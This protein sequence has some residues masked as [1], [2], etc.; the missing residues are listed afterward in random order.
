MSDAGKWQQVDEDVR[1]NL[2]HGIKLVRTFRGHTGFI[3]NI[4]WSPDGRMLATPSFDKTIRLWDPETGKCLFTLEGHKNSVKCV[5]FDP[6]GHILAS[7]SKDNSI[8]LWEPASG[9]L[10][11]TLKGHKAG[12]EGLVF[13]SHG[14]LISGSFDGTIKFWN[15]KDGRLQK[16]LHY[17]MRNSSLAII[18]IALDS[19]QEIL[20][21]AG[22][23]GVLKSWNLSNGHKLE[24]QGIENGFID[25]IAFNP[26]GRELAFG[27]SDSQIY[28]W[29]VA[30][31]LITRTLELHTDCIL[32]VGFSSDGKVIA[33]KGLD[34]I[35]SLWKYDS[36]AL[37]AKFSS[38][39]SGKIVGSLAFHPSLPIIAIVNSDPKAKI[40]DCGYVISIFEYDLDVLLQKPKIPTITYTSAKIVL[41]GD[42]GVGKSGLG[43]RLAHGEFKEHSSTHGQQFWLL[44]QLCKQRR[45]GAQCEAVL[46]DLAGQRDYRLIHALFLDDVDLALVL[47]D[48]THD[49][50]PLRGVEFW[51]KQLKVKAQPLSGT[52]TVLIAARTDRGSPRMT[53]EELN[54]FC[55]DR[56]IK[57]FYAPVQ[58][59]ARG[60]RI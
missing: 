19:R 27:G 25:T 39:T 52:P 31:G 6:L 36:G 17:G 59:L 60:S 32:S 30:K 28:L 16:T 49:D 8:M 46:W 24:S 37:L 33:A 18:N 57:A 26:D 47:F 35:V 10:L 2:P 45:D 41:V 22:N 5:A 51:L 50:D 23:S 20:V 11:F 34:G 15:T 58:N 54:A 44:N 53:E 3:G 21:G 42:S 7:G 1:K 4:A 48:P 38:K 43:W 40:N 13:G 29:D 14:L 12:I 9:K 55:K 56:G